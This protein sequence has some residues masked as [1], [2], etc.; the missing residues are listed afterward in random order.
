MGQ[1]TAGSMQL[2]AGGKTYP[3][4][5]QTIHKTS[6]LSPFSSRKVLSDW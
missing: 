3:W 5:Q 4:S 6:G 1:Q 2:A